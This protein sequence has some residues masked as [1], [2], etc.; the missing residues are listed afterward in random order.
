MD[1]LLS[2]VVGVILVIN[3]NKQQNQILEIEQKLY[4]L[5]MLSPTTLL[6]SNSNDLPYVDQSCNLFYYIGS[7][8]HGAHTFDVY[9]SAVAL[10][11]L[12]LSIAHYPDTRYPPSTC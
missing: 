12:V 9:D 5:R 8:C 4:V 6:F 11:T 7:S 2:F 10:S 1:V 3:H